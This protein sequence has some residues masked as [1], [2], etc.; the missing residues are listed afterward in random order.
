V[1]TGKIDGDKISW[2]ARDAR[3]VTGGPAVSD[4]YGTITSGEDG[5]KIDFVWRGGK[6][7]SGTFSLHRTK[8]K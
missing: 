5:D 7:K 3:A 6:G 4:F 2:L 1:V 8:T